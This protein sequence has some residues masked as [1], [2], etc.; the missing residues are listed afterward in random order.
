MS[1]L[2]LILLLYAVIPA[3]E[4]RSFNNEKVDGYKGIW[5]ELGEEFEYGDKYSGGLGTYTA[6][7]I[8]MAIYSPEVKKTFFVYGGT[9]AKEE[10]HLLCMIGCYNHKTNMVS[11]PTVVYDKINIDDPHDNP[12]IMIDNNGYVWVFVSGR[13]NERP[14]IKLKSIDPY[15]I[16]SLKSSVKKLLHI[17]RYGIPGKGTSIFLLN[18]QVKENCILKQVL[19]RINGP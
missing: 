16:N 7:H 10:K 5:F 15:N 2:L 9:T 4:S 17:H 19:M 6:K 12:T 18:T 8:P 11:K 3:Q 13:A 1:L 14:G